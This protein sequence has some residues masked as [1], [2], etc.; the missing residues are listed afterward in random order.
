[1][2]KE[3]AIERLEEFA[4]YVCDDTLEALYMAIDALQELPKQRKEAKRW[5]TKALQADMRGDTE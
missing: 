3:E 1:M 4:P 5:K 2:T